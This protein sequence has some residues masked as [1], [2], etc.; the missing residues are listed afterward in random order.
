ME[1]CDKSLERY[2][3]SPLQQQHRHTV[4]ASSRVPH[5]RRLIADKSN[6]SPERSDTSPVTSSTHSVAMK[7]DDSDYT[8]DEAYDED[9]TFW[10]HWQYGFLYR[11][12]KL[13]RLCC[14]T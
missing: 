8:G 5:K 1:E 13:C 11:P 4:T 12:T 3:T 14:C 6:E 7:K 2:S 9:V 10:S